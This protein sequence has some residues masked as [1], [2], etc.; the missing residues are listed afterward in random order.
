MPDISESKIKTLYQ[1]H[2]DQVGTM[3]DPKGSNNV[4]YNTLYYNRV[5]NDPKYHW[6]LVYIWA[7]FHENGMDDLFYGGKKTA[8]CTTFMNW[9]KSVNQWV[10][11][12]YKLGDIVF[13]NFDDNPWDVEH[14]GFYVGVLANGKISTIEGNTNDKV[15]Y[16]YR[17]P[18]TVAGA[19][20]P[21]YGD[22]PVVIPSPSTPEP[23]KPIVNKASVSLPVLKQGDKGQA[24]KTLQRLLIAN[25]YDVG[26]DRDDGDFG[27][28]TKLGLRKYQS[29]HGIL[30]DGICG[31]ET[32]AS[33]WGV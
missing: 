22:S 4:I 25:K 17:D 1:W 12:E 16:V 29:D 27:P 21:K 5:I 26:P 9:A 7:G 13:F 33:F 3:E 14:V 10:T 31:P 19:Y 18:K 30:V 23:N 8:S 6:C 28:N 24:V 2:Q 32:H 20:R 11:S 15:A